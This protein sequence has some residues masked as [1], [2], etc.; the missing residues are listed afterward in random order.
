MDM[1]N[2][3]QARKL[4]RITRDITYTFCAQIYNHSNDKIK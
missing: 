1:G 3:R 2:V 4:H